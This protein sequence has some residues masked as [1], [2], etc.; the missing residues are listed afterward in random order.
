MLGAPAI[1]RVTTARLTAARE[2]V[3]PTALLLAL[4][5]LLAGFVTLYPTLMLLR[6]SLSTGR[7]GNPGPLTLQNYAAV[8]GS[9]ETYQLLW[10]TAQYA[11]G[12]AVVSVLVGFVLAWICVRTNTPLAEHMP[13]L[14]FIPYALPST[15]T[16]VAWTLLANPN[17]GFLNELARAVFGSGATPFNIYS[18]G[19]M[20]FVASTHAFALA[21]AFLTASLY[22]MDPALE[23][24]A[25]TAGAGPVR[26][27]WKVTLPLAW[28]AVFSTL[29]LLFILG[30]ESFDVPAFIGIPA[31]IYV[32]TTQVFVQT[33][34]KVPPD[35]GQAATYGVLPLLFALVL[36][37]AF[38]R[39]I[40]QPERY[41]TISGKAY[42]PRRIDLGRWRWFALGVFLLVFF[43]CAVLPV[44]TLLLVS[45]APTLLAAKSFTLG[46]FG[47]QHYHTI[48]GDPV[49]QRAIRNTL[50]LALLGATIAM[51]MAFFVAYVTTRTKGA[52][53]GLLEY[54]LFLPFTFP[55]VVLAVGILWGYIR[56]PIAVY[57]TVWILMIGY[58]TKFLPYG[59][60][61]LS[62]AMLQVHRELEEAARISGAGF[63]QV[64][65]RVIFP[66]SLPGL[67]AGWS[68][69]VIV[70]MRE[71]SVSLM[72]WSSGSEVVT[73]LFYDYWTNGRYGQLGALGMLLVIA[74]LL[75]VFGVRR[76][77]GLDAQRR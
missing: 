74:S 17:T 24:A 18:F 39:I 49:A 77:A 50:L 58:V 21:F 37:Y 63:G 67:I 27:A 52:G 45:V 55:S 5:L 16:S 43:I 36:T 29:A 8:Y 22:S 35:Y 70:F 13:W 38:R 53:R 20:V 40:V 25:S 44:G 32:F 42:R 62:A 66:L 71:F 64:L 34:V 57:G 76:L 47:L 3:S 69:L 51:A 4:V 2:R 41:A 56:F 59:L 12:L 31:K 9:L 65:R 28:P 19:G 33:S 68:L 7:I 72:L 6:G 46:S 54:V 61:S 75:I 10:T 30:L 11:V 1:G 60:R 23:E 48:L 15:L 26:T 73:V 14:V